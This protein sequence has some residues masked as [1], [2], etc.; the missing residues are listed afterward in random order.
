MLVVGRFVVGVGIGVSAVVV[1]TYLGEV[2]PAKYRG[3]VVEL[4]EVGGARALR[5]SAV[6]CWRSFAGRQGLRLW[7]R[8]SKAPGKPPA[9]LLVSTMECERGWTVAEGAGHVMLLCRRCCCVW[10][11][12]RRR[13]GA[14]GWPLLLGR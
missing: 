2:A 12:W 3:R 11:C 13:S 10:A 7:E 5:G 6:R 8:R 1:P 4:Y 9:W 14:A